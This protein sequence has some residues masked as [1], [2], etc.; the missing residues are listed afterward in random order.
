MG[1]DFV[2]FTLGLARN[3][4]WSGEGRNI[5]GEAEKRRNGVKAG[6][7]LPRKSN[8]VPASLQAGSYESMS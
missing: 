1:S 3:S 7:V 8:T 5:R 6:P 4:G 2:G